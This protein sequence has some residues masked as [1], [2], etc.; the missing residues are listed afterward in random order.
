MERVSEKD[1]EWLL[2][3]NQ[4]FN[5]KSEIREEKVHKLSLK[6]KATR[7]GLWALLILALTILPFFLL[8]KTSIFLNT[9]Q[10]LNGWVSLLGGMG[11]TI[12]ILLVYVVMLFRK[13]KNKKLLLRFSLG[14]IG[15]LVG[16]FC[17]YGLLYL[18][19]VNAK[20]D[21]VKEVYRSLHPILRVAVATTTL[22]EGNL[23][24]TDI[25]RS[26]EDYAKIGLPINQSSLHFPQPDGYV[27][28]ID[29]RTKGHSE[30]RNFLLSNSLRLMGFKTL[31]HVGT[32]DHLHISLPN[33][34]H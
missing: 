18:S 4:D 24:I 26:M 15:A 1:I 8:I 10:G 6:R 23:V 30:V 17:L 32:A 5:Y 25:K 20:S 21:S 12:S 14:G 34:K 13:V 29:L 33:S 27:H 3:P 28:A 9:E 31:R 2:K 22:A 19:S 11:A 16:G 7:I